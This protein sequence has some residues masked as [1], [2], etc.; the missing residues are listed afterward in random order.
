MSDSPIGKAAHSAQTAPV[1]PIVIINAWHDDNAGDSAIAEVCIQF[2]REFWPNHPINVHTMLASADPA[3]DHWNRHL[4]AENPDVTFKPAMFPEP[5]SGGPWRKLKLLVRSAMSAPLL[6]K[7]LPAPGRSAALAYVAGA[8]RIIVVGGSDLFQLKRPAI[9]SALRL[10]RILEPCQLANRLGV[11]YHLWGHTLGPFEDGRGQRYMRSILSGAQEVVVR[12]K[13]SRALALEIAPSAN[14]VELPD[15]AFALNSDEATQTE[16]AAS[17]PLRY[18]AIVPR[19]H[20]LDD[21]ASQEPKLI[22]EFAKLALLLLEADLV[23]Q[24][25]VVPQVVGPSSIENDEFIAQKIAA[26]ASDPRVV[27]VSG[28]KSPSELRSLYANAT[29]VVAVRLHGAILSISAGTPAFAISYFTAKTQGVLEGAGMHDSWTTIEQFDAAS[30]VEWWR[31]NTDEASRS[32][33]SLIASQH[34]VALESLRG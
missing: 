28:G 29:G 21:Q 13:I 2:A 8:E 7:S 3:Y 18:A 23:D 24:V 27:T 22:A 11:P 19:G 12:E 9:T 31:N 17:Q 34:R 4:R 30:T 33:A 10:R 26:S 20:I 25:L 32:K 15:F 16:S 14:V 1:K 6:L 5:V